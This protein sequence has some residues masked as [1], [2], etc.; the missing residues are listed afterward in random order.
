MRHFGGMLHL[1]DSTV[2][3]GYLESVP[4]VEILTDE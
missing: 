4:E 3:V 2:K 1:A